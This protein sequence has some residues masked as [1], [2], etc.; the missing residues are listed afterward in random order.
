M[1]NK[2]DLSAKSRKQFTA[3]DMSGLFSSALAI[4]KDEIVPIVQLP[5]GDLI[6]R[7]EQPFKPYSAAKLRQLSE[8]IKVN[9]V[10]NPII[11]RPHE[12]QY[13]ILAGHNRWNA[14]RLAGLNTIP[15]IVRDVDDDVAI[16]IMVNTN[17]NQRDQLLPS[18]KAFAYK[19]QLEAMKRQAGRRSK[20]N[21]SQNG[22][23]KRSDE[24]LAEQAG[25]S[26]NQIARYIRLTNLVPELLEM[27]DSGMLG[28]I[29]AEKLSYLSQKAQALICDI[30]AECDKKISTA[31]AQRLK[32]VEQRNDLNE[33]KIREILLPEKPWNPQTVFVSNTKKLIPETATSDDISMITKMIE[34]YFNRK[35]QES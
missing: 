9:G 27:V 34:E 29:P 7:K 22:T 32:E 3:A 25:E 10:I 12:N 13:E 15:A 33:I 5:I 23:Q 11:V 8:D 16:L 18:E 4:G 31:Q 24:I 1:G 14:S 6:P 35:V 21:A 17:L 20:E 2:I 19:M 28:F 30:S 26:R